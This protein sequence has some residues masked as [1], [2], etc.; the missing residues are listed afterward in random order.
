[1]KLINLLFSLVLLLFF[2]SI[3]SFYSYKIFVRVEDT[4]SQIKQEYVIK[5]F[6]VYFQEDA[7]SLGRL[8]REYQFTFDGNNIIASTDM[9]VDNSFLESLQAKYPGLNSELE[10]LVTPITIELDGKK[11]PVIVVKTSDRTEIHG[12]TGLITDEKAIKG[13]KEMMASRVASVPPAPSDPIPPKSPISPPLNNELPK[14][15]EKNVNM[16]FSVV[17]QL[18]GGNTLF[19][20]ELYAPKDGSSVVGKYVVSGDK[21]ELKVA[22]N[23]KNLKVATVK[24]VYK[25]GSYTLETDWGLKGQ[26]SDVKEFI[27]KNMRL[28]RKN[29]NLELEIINLDIIQTFK[30]QDNKIVQDIALKEK[31][32]ISSSTDSLTLMSTGD[33]QPAGQNEVAGETEGSDGKVVEDG[34]QKLRL[35]VR[36]ALE[37]YQKAWNNLQNMLNERIFSIQDALKITNDKENKIIKVEIKT[38]SS[39]KDFSLQSYENSLALTNMELSEKESL[40]LKELANRGIIMKNGNLDSLDPSKMQALKDYFNIKI[41]PDPIPGQ[42]VQKVP[43]IFCIY[44]EFDEYWKQQKSGS[45]NERLIDIVSNEEYQK[46]LQLDEDMIEF[47]KALVMTEIQNTIE[48]RVGDKAHLLTEENYLAIVEGTYYQALNDLRQFT[49][50]QYEKGMNQQYTTELIKFLEEQYTKIE[51]QLKDMKSKEDNQINNKP[52]EEVMPSDNLPPKQDGENISSTENPS[53]ELSE[54]ESCRGRGCI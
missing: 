51:E 42:V 31:G 7:S 1:M 4:K 52:K 36:Q 3:P 2:L 53:S 38:P 13:V 25:D 43:Q 5:R 35:E 40:V 41:A 21:T 6:L 22:S 20:V 16:K 47:Y 27:E 46:T 26:N 29:G 24:V 8:I 49:M 33:N 50:L 54:E 12:A 28:I 11:T 15:E 10:K 14:V 32:V 23:E 34:Q 37:N 17:P 45:D 48:G 9:V 18:S 39:T 19:S 30:L 44:E